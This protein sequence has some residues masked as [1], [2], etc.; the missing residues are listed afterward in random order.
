M[1]Y[2]TREKNIAAG[3]AKAAA[4]A[5][6]AAAAANADAAAQAAAA[7]AAKALHKESGAVWAHIPSGTDPAVLPGD[8]KEHDFKRSATDISDNVHIGEHWDGP[9][10]GRI[11]REYRRAM[12]TCNIS[13]TSKCTHTALGGEYPDNQAAF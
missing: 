13:G 1:D 8:I 6:A 7:A 4:D 9:K 2:W 12:D 10:R 11:I 3:N 5:A